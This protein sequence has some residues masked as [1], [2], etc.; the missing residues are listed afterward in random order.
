MGSFRDLIGGRK[1]STF[2]LSMQ[3]C[4]CFLGNPRSMKCVFMFCSA[5]VSSVSVLMM[6]HSLSAWLYG[7]DLM[8]CGGWQDL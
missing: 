7:M 2:A 4:M 6:R 8:M 5:V 1:W 3:C